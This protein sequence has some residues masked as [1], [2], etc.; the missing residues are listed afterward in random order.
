M[1]RE[2]VETLLEQHGI[3]PTRP[4]T[5]AAELLLSRKQHVTADQLLDQL[6]ASESPVSRA[7]VYNTLKLFARHGVIRQ[8]L[9]DG[10]KTLYDSNTSDH[11]H[12]YNVET[13]ELTDIPSSSLSLADDLGLPDGTEIEGMDVVVRVR[14]QNH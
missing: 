11:Y 9:L 7:T 14:T 4:R 6:N 5:D 10:G 2:D 3:Q 1:K 12:I 13:G 8:V